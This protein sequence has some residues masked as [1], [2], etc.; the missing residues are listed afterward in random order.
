MNWMDRIVIILEQP[1]YTG[2]IGMIC[3]LNANF[4]LPPL[5][6]I[7]EMPKIDQ[8]MQWMAHNSHD[9]FAKIQTFV[10]IEQASIDLNYVIGTGMIKGRDRGPYL[11]LSQLPSFLQQNTPEKIGIVFGREDSGLKANTVTYCDYLIHFELPGYQPSMNL[12][13]SVAY[14]LSILHNYPLQVQHRKQANPQDKKH[15]YDYAERVFA[16]LGMTEFHDKK[17]LAVKRLKS[18]LDTRPI[19]SGDLGFLYK[20]F[21]N[22]E[23]LYRG[24]D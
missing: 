14:V 21:R 1:K 4:C 6:I 17:N 18:I 19:H 13:H 16:M 23:K 2:N 20:I 5:R 24:K 22:I 7:G 11:K 15:F 9:E 12:S 3:R 8:Q 10:N